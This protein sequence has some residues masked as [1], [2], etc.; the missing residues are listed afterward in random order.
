MLGLDIGGSAAPSIVTHC[1]G[2]AV[3]NVITAAM[4]LINVVPVLLL[5]EKLGIHLLLLLLLLLQ[6][7]VGGCL[8][9]LHGTALVGLD[10]HGPG[11]LDLQLLLLDTVLLLL[12]LLLIIIMI[13]IMV[14]SLGG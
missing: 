8:E 11:L 13:L 10:L 5:E 6:L 9:T 4:L 14:V 3:S 1:A 2:H 12:M 7:V